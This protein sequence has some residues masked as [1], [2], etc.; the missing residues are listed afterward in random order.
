VVV[1]SF[2]S[3]VA[4]GCIGVSYL[5]Y[6]GGKGNIF[7]IHFSELSG[8]NYF[9]GACVLFGAVVLYFVVN[10]ILEVIR[11][12]HLHDDDEEDKK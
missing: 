7:G 11:G 4:L 9:I 6:L 1:F 12:E 2:F 5:L 8:V 3:L 10:Y